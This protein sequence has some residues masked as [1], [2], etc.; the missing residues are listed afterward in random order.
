L[1]PPLRLAVRDH[2]PHYQGA[3]TLLIGPDRLEGG[4][5][6]RVP[7]KDKQPQHHRQVTRDYWIAV[8]ENAGVL[9]VY[10]ERLPGAGNEGDDKDTVQAW[11]LHGMY[12]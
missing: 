3:L 10:Q 5:W 4:W 9:A 7:A 1:D 11:Y 8:N 6:D 2:R 12:A